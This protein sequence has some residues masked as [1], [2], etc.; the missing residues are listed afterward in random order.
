M[1][2]LLNGALTQWD[3]NRYVKV[4]VNDSDKTYEVHCYGE[5]DTVALNVK[6]EREGNV[7]LAPIPNILLQNNKKIVVC[8]VEISGDTHRT[9][10]ISTLYICCRV[11]PEDYVY[12]ETEIKSYEA[13]EK[14]IE[15]LEE[16]GGVSDEQIAEA[17]N[18]YMEN[19]P[20]DIPTDCV[21]SVNGILPDEN[22]DVEIEVGEGGGE[23]RLLKND[24]LTE[25]VTTLVIKSETPLNEF[26]LKFNGRANDADDTLTSGSVVCGFR[27]IFNG[28]IHSSG[29]ANF[30][31][32]LLKS[33]LFSYIH[34]KRENILLKA[35]AAGGGY[36]CYISGDAFSHGTWSG[37]DIYNFNGFYMQLYNATDKYI[38]A[39]STLEVWVR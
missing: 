1:I 3:L 20:I 26:M 32:R 11:K 22:G 27:P 28:T 17:V 35:T 15:A 9:V 37:D 16:S 19:N 36:G 7:I 38:K 34:I 29:I 6:T 23:W 13:L 24:T 12:T 5:N 14:R 10:E 18:E 4:T 30:P 33:N 25:D 39:G 21:K 31:I 2:E 8:V